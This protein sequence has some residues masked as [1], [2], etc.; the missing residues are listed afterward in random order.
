MIIKPTTTRAVI[1]GLMVLLSMQCFAQELT[2]VGEKTDSL[3]NSSI[4][5]KNVIMI[6]AGSSLL[7]NEKIIPEIENFFQIQYKR[8]MTS[9]LNINGNLKKFDIE[10]FGFETEGFLSGDLN[11]EWYVFPDNKLTPSVFIG[12]GILTSN[13]FND[14][15]YK[16][17]G[18]IGLDYL[19]TNSIAIAGSIETNYVYDEQKGSIIMQ[20]ID[21]LYFNAVIGLHFYIGCRNKSNSSKKIKSNQ[22]STINSNLIGV[23]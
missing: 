4:R 19:I 22:T 1:L 2:T 7:N 16:V 6:G 14:Q 10:D 5:A 3:S 8:F 18:G 21:E 9:N 20:G 12:A 13:D 23:N 11:L 15:N 17:Q